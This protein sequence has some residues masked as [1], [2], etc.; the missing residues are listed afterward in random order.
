MHGRDVAATHIR[1]RQESGNLI[2]SLRRVAVTRLS[3]P[4]SSS[5]L[6]HGRLDGENII[7][8]DGEIAYEFV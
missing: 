4:I 6:R 3:F 8:K 7:E 5:L 2:P 1:R